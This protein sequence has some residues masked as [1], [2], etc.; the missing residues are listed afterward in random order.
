MLEVDFSS[1]PA[2]WEPCDPDYIPTGTYELVHRND[3]G[4]AVKRLTCETQ[5]IVGLMMAI[6]MGKIT[7]KSVD[8]FIVRA[9]IW[10]DIVGPMGGGVVPGPNPLLVAAKAMLKQMHEETTFRQRHAL[11]D[12]FGTE[13]TAV[14]APAAEAI[15]AEPMPRIQYERITAKD[16]RKHIGMKGNVAKVTWPEF[17]KRCRRA[18]MDRL[19]REARAETRTESSAA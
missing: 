3:D 18:V 5:G 11:H 7:E 10:Q 8:E 1:I 17:H 14:M 15:K 9:E 4:K 6:G 16:I 2:A 13:R 12:R 19:A